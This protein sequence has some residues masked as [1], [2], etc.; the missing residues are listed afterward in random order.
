MVAG[1]VNERMAVLG[2]DRGKINGGVIY[3][4]RC[5]RKY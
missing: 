3:G 4:A 2:S 5:E 1:E